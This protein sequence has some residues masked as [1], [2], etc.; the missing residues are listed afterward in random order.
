[1]WIRGDKIK[2]ETKLKLYRALVKPILLYNSG[3]WALTKADEDNIDA[4]HRK[5]LRRVLNIKYP[6]I[7]T[8]ESLYRQTKERP[9]SSEIREQRWRLFGHILRRDAEIPAN[10]AMTAY[11]LKCGEP[12]RGRPIT[13]MPIV[14]NHDLKLTEHTMSL[15]SEQ[16][17][18][19]IRKVATNRDQWK[20]LQQDVVGAAEA[21]QSIDRDAKGP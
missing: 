10:Q 16:D 9:L 3:T 5:Q 1:M 17:L 15:K 4:F 8:N 13:T 6:K 12:Y 11:F 14:L 2:K 19:Q 21:S 20:Q 18:E 7:I